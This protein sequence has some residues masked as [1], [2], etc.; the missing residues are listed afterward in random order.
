VSLQH[1]RDFYGI[2]GAQDL[3]PRRSDVQPAGN[4]VITSD[5]ALR[6]SAVWACLRLRANLISTMPVDAFRKV[7]KV[8]VEIGKP[9]VLVNPGGERVDIQEWLY[10][11]QFDLDRS[12]NCFGLI[13]E[14]SGMGL[15]ARID[16]VAASEVAVVVRQ[17]KLDHYR[18]GSET[19]QP[20]EV[21][22]ERQYTVAGLHVGL[23]PVAYSA[24]AVGEYLNITQFALSWFGNGQHP[25]AMLRNSQ[26][27][28][29]PKEAQAIKE[30]FK[31]AVKSGDLFV[32]GADWE[33]QM[34]QA[35]QAGSQWLEAK[36][37]S[38]VDVARFF[39]CPADL[40]DA[41]VQGD[42]ITYAN[43]VQRNLQLLIM[44]LNPALRRREAALSRLL[45]VPRFVKFNRGALLE[46]DPRTRAEM[47]NLA[48]EG[49]WRSPSEVRALE[50]LPPMTEEQMAEFDRLFGP[51]KTSLAPAGAGKT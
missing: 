49:R 13:T 41:A 44:H 4:I 20:F 1:K 25:S 27:T 39:D 3:I 23:S 26:K 28:I 33:Y 15:P 40:I 32:T 34:L 8:Q 46:M 10:S 47:F 29:Q 9:P 12:G 7:N 17:G 2:S 14:R 50:N 24:W 48:I 35:E 18:I 30:R 21:W 31:T 5:M 43:I 19:Y 22:H 51:P 37:A 11:S 38:V 45:P 6:H 42:S 16:L 36:G